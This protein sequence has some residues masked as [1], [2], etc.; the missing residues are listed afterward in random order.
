MY[1]IK[2]FEFLRKEN[3]KVSL[4]GVKALKSQYTWDEVTPTLR[5]LY[6]WGF[7]SLIS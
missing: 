2:Y 5:A 7:H 3:S 4:I 6:Y 1:S